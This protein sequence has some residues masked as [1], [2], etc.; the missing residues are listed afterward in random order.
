[1]ENEKRKHEGIKVTLIGLL[2]NI[3]LTLLKIFLGIV[4]KSKALIADGFHSLSDFITDIIVI[5][6]LKFSSKPVDESHDY[7]HGKIETFATFVVGIF[8]IFVGVFIF[9]SSVKT[10]FSIFKGYHV[11][12]PT[13]ITFI[14]AF[15]SIIIK[16]GLYRYTIFIADKIKSQSIKANAWHHRSDAFSSVATSIGIGLAVFNKS[17]IIFDPISAI[18]V[19]F[20][21]IKVGFDIVKDAY[22]ELT[23][24]SLTSKEE[25]DILKIINSVDGVL[26]PH[27]IQTRRIGN[28]IAIDIHIEVDKSITVEKAHKIT[29]IVEDKL[30]EKYGKNFYINIHIEPSN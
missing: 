5:F 15:L 10:I 3:I 26:N 16:E 11:I 28:Y 18:I 4:G 19:T 2:V 14:F 25:D 24:K 20:F 9:Y 12:Q 29:E 1:M 13:S 22:D 8:L 23:E 21:I 17:L 27:S 7:G 30:T 6:G